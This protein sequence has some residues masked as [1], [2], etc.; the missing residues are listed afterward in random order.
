MGSPSR[1]LVA[2]ITAAGCFLSGKGAL[3]AARMNF[4]AK[5]AQHAVGEQRRVQ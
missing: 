2:E 1:A 5:A 3:D 4:A